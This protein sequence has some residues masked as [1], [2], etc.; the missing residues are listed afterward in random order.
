MLT[1]LEDFQCKE[2]EKLKYFS[3]SPPS[4]QI[5]N[6]SAPSLQII[7]PLVPSL[8]IINPSAPSL[9]IIKS[10]APSLQ[11]IKPSAPSLQ[12]INPSAPSLQIVNSS[13]QKIIPSFP[14][15]SINENGTI[16]KSYRRLSKGY[17][18]KIKYSGSSKA[19][20]VIDEQF[21]SIIYLVAE[22]YLPN[23]HNH[24]FVKHIGDNTDH[25]FS[26]LKWFSGSDEHEFLEWRDIPGHEGYKKLYVNIQ[27]LYKNTVPVFRIPQKRDAD[28]YV[29]CLSENNNGY[30]IQTEELAAKAFI[31]NPNNYPYVTFIG[32]KNK[33][34]ISNLRWSNVPIQGYEDLEFKPIEN[35]IYYK[36]SEHGDLLSFMS[37]IPVIKEPYLDANEGKCKRKYVIVEDDKREYI[38]LSDYLVARAFIPNPHNYKYVVHLDSNHNNDHYT[39]LLWSEIPE[40]P[41]GMEWREIPSFEDYKLSKNGLSNRINILFQ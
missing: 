11:I 39:N 12:I 37:K 23:P 19:K 22:T 1:A 28:I 31:S 33:R 5:I 15:Y 29:V 7:N 26:N 17:V 27:K 40:I 36:I 41:D 8:Q 14:N 6:P 9:Q 32:D 24:L 35:A 3:V 10:S 30:H 2:S 18:M 38:Y 4:L 20:V 21:R 13:V 34:H 25:H 16:V